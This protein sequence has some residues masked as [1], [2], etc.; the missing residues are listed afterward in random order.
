MVG[1]EQEQHEAA[2]YKSISNIRPITGHNSP[3]IGPLWNVLVEPR[4]Q[5]GIVL[6]KTQPDIQIRDFNSN[7]SNVKSNK[8]TGICLGGRQYEG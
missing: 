8:V 3:F 4:K 7:C 1:G 2:G 6:M 5:R